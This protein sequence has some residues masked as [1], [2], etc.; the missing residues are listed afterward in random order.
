MIRQG[1]RDLGDSLGNLGFPCPPGTPLP[2]LLLDVLEK[3]GENVDATDHEKKLEGLR[4]LTDSSAPC[5]LQRKFDDFEAG[6]FLG[7][8]EHVQCSAAF[9]NIQHAHIYTATYS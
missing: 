7:R 2:E 8:L 1:R 9:F 6:K 4:M 5:L 3:P